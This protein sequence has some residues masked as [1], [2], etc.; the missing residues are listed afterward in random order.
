M[1]PSLMQPSRVRF[2]GF[3]NIATVL[4]QEMEFSV[5]ALTGSKKQ[6]TRFVISL[7]ANPLLSV[8]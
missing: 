7:D 5:S 3:E 1:R 6:T 2:H 8:L 4:C